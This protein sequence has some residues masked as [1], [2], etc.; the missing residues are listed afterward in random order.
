MDGAVLREGHDVER[1]DHHQCI[2]DQ[3]TRLAMFEAFRRDGWTRATR[4]SSTAT[5]CCTP[6]AYQP[7]GQR[8]LQD[9]YFEVDD[10]F[11]HLARMSGE[12][13]NAMVHS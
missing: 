12:A 9:V 3:V 7:D 2:A 5:G 8:H 1:F 6:A 13:T 11:G 4:C 10:V